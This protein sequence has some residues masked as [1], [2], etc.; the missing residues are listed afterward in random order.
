M[1]TV[2]DLPRP[3]PPPFD[4]GT[5]AFRHTVLVAAKRFKSTW[6][7]LGKLLTQ[8]RDQ[9]LYEGWGYPSFEAY[10]LAELRIRKQTALK[11]TRS[12]SF[13]DRHEPKALERPELRE[14]APPFEVVE[15]LAGAEER[16]QLSA[17]EYTSVRDAIWNQDRPV[18]ELKRELEDRFPAPP[19][20]VSSAQEL[21]R[22][23]TQA[24]RLHAELQAQKKVPRDVVK[25]AEDLARQLE[26]LVAEG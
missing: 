5:D 14:A 21:K 8:V 18:S 10:C 17:Q 16:G 26:A 23:W 20:K 1:A 9:A 2:V 25:A 6:V 15:V 19:P 22:L 12:F 4:P 24:K 11:L 3:P 7:D 13:L